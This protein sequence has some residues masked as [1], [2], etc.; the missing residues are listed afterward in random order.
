[1]SA[2][3]HENRSQPDLPDASIE[4]APTLDALMAPSHFKQ[5]PAAI[6]PY[7]ILARLGQGGMGTVYEAEQ[8]HPR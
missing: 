1:M 6:G 7:L 8:P 2:D 5:L 3:P 4:H